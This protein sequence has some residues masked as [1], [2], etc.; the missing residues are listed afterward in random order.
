MRSDDD[1]DPSA[2]LPEGAFDGRHAFEARLRSAFAAAAQ[3][4][5]PEFVW[6]DPD[7]VDWPL[8]ERS[9]IDALQG[10]ASAGRQL[11]LVAQRFDVAEREHAR[12]VHW[13]RMWSHIIDCRVCSGPGMPQVPSAIWTPSW[14]LHRIDVDR[15]R[16]VCGR[17]P[18]SRRAV[19]ER[20]DECLRHAKSGFPAS[21][22]GL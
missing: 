2:G 9:V 8:G 14:F 4:Q 10:W 12:F 6:S 11:V 21:T 16:G 15:V 7:F 1:G 13:R 17:S 5:W 20:I 19:R 18:E 3:Q 22:L